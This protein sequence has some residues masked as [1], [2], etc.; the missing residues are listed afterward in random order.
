[1]PHVTTHRCK[2]FLLD[3][4]V[5]DEMEYFGCDVD[6]KTDMAVIGCSQKFTAGVNQYYGAAYVATSSGGQW[7]AGGLH[8]VLTASTLVNN[9]YFGYS[10]AMS[11]DQS[12]IIVGAPYE[13]VTGT[14]HIFT[15]SSGY[16]RNRAGAYSKSVEKCS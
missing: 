3:D 1:M 6:I 4:Y 5:A 11:L 10:V 9:S 8:C 2:T 14:V 12:T 16:Y 7:G 15:E 13:N